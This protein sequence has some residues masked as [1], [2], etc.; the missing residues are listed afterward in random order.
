MGARLYEPETGRFTSVDPL[1]EAFKRWSP[2]AYS[3]NNPLTFRDPTGLAP[4][5]EK[6]KDEIMAWPGPDIVALTY[7]YWVETMESNFNNYWDQHILMNKAN[8]GFLLSI[9]V[10]YGG[11]ENWYKAAG[12]K[13]RKQGRLAQDIKNGAEG[14]NSNGVVERVN[15]DEGQHISNMTAEDFQR[16]SADVREALRYRS[17]VDGVEWGCTVFYDPDTHQLVFTNFKSGTENAVSLDLEYSGLDLVAAIHTHLPGY[18][19]WFSNE[20]IFF[21]YHMHMNKDGSNKEFAFKPF[22]IVET[23]SNTFYARVESIY[24][25]M[26]H[27]REDTKLYSNREHYQK[28]Y[29][30][31][32]ITTIPGI[33]FQTFERKK[34]RR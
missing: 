5:K 3:Y 10:R 21:M 12:T 1:F 18:D 32:S 25:F 34:R 22:N 31:D 23:N 28:Y 9:I 13:T 7:G 15:V 2:Y 24:I 6:Y 29:I 11:I 27:V 8:K 19:N 14:G 17:E 20:D 16:Y 30:I 4:E 33:L 26:A